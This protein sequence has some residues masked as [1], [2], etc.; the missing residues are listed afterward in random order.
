[1][2][3]TL[4]YEEEIKESDPYFGDIAEGKLDAE[5]LGLAK[6]LIKRRTASFKPE[7]FHDHYREALR[8]LIDARLEHR[9]PREVVEEKPAGKV[10]NLMDALRKSL[11]AQ[12]GKE[13]APAKATH[14]TKAKPKGK[15]KAK[16]EAK[17]KPKPK[18]KGR[19]G[20]K[21]A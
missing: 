17:A 7:K 21:A 2:L 10:L 20:R 4:R 6:E 14:K 8:E 9:A 19:G 11:K 1:L 15:T 12:G 3:E 5:Q 13:P 16:A 18:P